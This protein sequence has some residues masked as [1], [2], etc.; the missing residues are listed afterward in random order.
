MKKKFTLNN[1]ETNCFDSEPVEVLDKGL[2]IN[3]VLGFDPAKDCKTVNGFKAF[4]NTM[5][6][7]LAHKMV[8]RV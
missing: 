4:L 7:K 2:N 6:V 1:K 3:Q 8:E 5:N